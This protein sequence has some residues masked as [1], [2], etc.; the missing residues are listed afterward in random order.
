MARPFNKNLIKEID[1][2]GE[3]KKKEFIQRFLQSLPKLPDVPAGA[4]AVQPAVPLVS[5]QVQESMRQ[6]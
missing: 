6:E 4:I 3:N 1:K 2:A 5:E